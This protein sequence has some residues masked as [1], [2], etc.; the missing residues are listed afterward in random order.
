MHDPTDRNTNSLPSSMMLSSPNRLLN[1]HAPKLS[2][3]SQQQNLSK[4]MKVSHMNGGVR[5]TSHDG[6][7]VIRS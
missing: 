1:T 7:S 2:R 3:P 5:S 6:T 4:K